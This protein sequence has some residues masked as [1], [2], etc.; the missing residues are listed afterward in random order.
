MSGLIFNPVEYRACD[1]QHPAFY[2]CVHGS[3]LDIELFFN[4]R[5]Y[6]TR[7]EDIFYGVAGA[8]KFDRRLIIQYLI[9]LG[10]D[11]QNWNENYSLAIHCNHVIVVDCLLR[12]QVNLRNL[13]LQDGLCIAFLKGNDKII[14]LIVDSKQIKKINWFDCLFFWFSNQS[15]KD[16]ELIRYMIARQQPD[17]LVPF[18]QKIIDNFQMHLIGGHDKNDFLNILFHIFQNEFHISKH[19]LTLNQVIVHKCTDAQRFLSIAKFEK[20]NKKLKQSCLMKII[21]Q[22]EHVNLI[23]YCKQFISPV[24]SHR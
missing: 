7:S 11:K 9:K 5:S 20:M 16:F 22:I 21:N 12:Q 8:G 14:E 17:D 18:L 24:L 23:F 3:I 2:V 19:Q 1:F 15:T 6:K 13:C 10:G 4:T